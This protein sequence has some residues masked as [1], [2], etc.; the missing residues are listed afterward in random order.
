VERLAASNSEFRLLNQAGSVVFEI[1][2]EG[3]DPCHL[4]ADSPLALLAEH[5]VL[6]QPSAQLYDLDVGIIDLPQLAFGQ[7]P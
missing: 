7:G 3:S 1:G 4:R 6:N 2:L 5:L